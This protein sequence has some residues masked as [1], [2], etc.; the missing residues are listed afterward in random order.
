MIQFLEIKKKIGGV[1]AKGVLMTLQE[2]E[3]YLTK[4]I[5]P[6]TDKYIQQQVLAKSMHF[7]KI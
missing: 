5:K 3:K 2:A 1:V 4:G 6:E 7:T